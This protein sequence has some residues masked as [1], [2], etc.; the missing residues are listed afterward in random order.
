MNTE[1]CLVIAGR[2]LVDA[3]NAETEARVVR[4]VRGFESE[5]LCAVQRAQAARGILGAEIVASIYGWSV[6]YDSGLQ[7]FGILAGARAKQ[8]D[9]SFTDAAAWAAAWVAQDPER[10]YAWVRK[11]SLEREGVLEVELPGGCGAARNP[12]RFPK[13]FSIDDGK[14]V[15]AQKNAKGWLNAINYM[16]PHASGGVGNLCPHASAG[17]IA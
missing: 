17:C 13:F 14:A 16:A 5:G 12:I 10:R 8:V 7:N 11:A 4:D 3:L 15:K 6:R 1:H 9:G 2:P